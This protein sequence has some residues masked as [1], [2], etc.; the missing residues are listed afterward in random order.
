[1]K[2][3]T[4]RPTV[5]IPVIPTAVLIREYLATDQKKKSIYRSQFHRGRI[6]Q[7]DLPVVEEVIQ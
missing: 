4:R 5:E 2:D 1:M 7:I 6:T 3:S